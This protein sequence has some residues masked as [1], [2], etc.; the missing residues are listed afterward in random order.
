MNL[1]TYLASSFTKTLS[2]RK[3]VALSAIAAI[4]FMLMFSAIPAMALSLETVNNEPQIHSHV[5]Q[6]ICDNLKALLAL[7]GDR[8][9]EGLVNAITDFCAETH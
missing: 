5:P 9:S 8:A 2:G 3:Y 6:V 7:A 4:T 1:K